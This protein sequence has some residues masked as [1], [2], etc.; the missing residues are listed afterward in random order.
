MNKSL[1][2][3]QTAAICTLKNAI[4]EKR[5][6]IDEFGAKI[7][8][9]P[10][11]LTCIFS[12]AWGLTNDRINA[13]AAILGEEYKKILAPIKAAEKTTKHN[14]ESQKL[15]LCRDCKNVCGRCSWSQSLTPVDG[16][17]AEKS[18]IL[19]GKKHTPTWRVLKCP[20]YEEYKR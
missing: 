15:H 19:S 13:I 11:T 8:F 3:E 4:A 5:M 10:K 2:V 16:W 12:G 7:G 20:K 6:T 18:Y 9:R 1:T 14:L 17:T